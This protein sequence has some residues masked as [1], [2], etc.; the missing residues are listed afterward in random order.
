VRIDRLIKEMAKIITDIF[1]K[2]IKCQVNVGEGTWPVSGLATQLHQVLMN[3]CV[4]ARD[5]MPQGG[6]LKLS[7]NNA[8][9]GK[10]EVSE[11]PEVA[12]GHYVCV[13]VEDT[14]TG[15]SPEQLAKLFQPFFTT[16]APGKGT[17]LGLSTSR[18]I[19]RNH[20]GF[21]TVESQA[22]QGTAFKFYLPAANAPENRE[23]ASSPSALPAGSGQCVLVVD[24]EETVLAI[25][26]STLENFGYVVITASSGPESVAYFADQR[27]KIKLVITDMSMPFMDGV[28]TTMALRKIKAD[29]PIILTSGLDHDKD[30][31]TSRRVKAA[32]ILLK[33]FTAETLLK[34]VH[35][36]LTGAHSE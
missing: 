1:P 24:D 11:H 32:A 34:Q 23:S 29:V 8:Q 19:I 22:G 17:G 26:K 3:L 16:K 27:E 13:S 21:I 2:N 15:I 12:P 36:V 14:G 18:N 4:N 30:G 25:T 31:D 6:T 10:S 20:G 33:P 5:A 9:L 7:T 35:A 28:A